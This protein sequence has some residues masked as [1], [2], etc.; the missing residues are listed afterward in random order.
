MGEMRGKRGRGRRLKSHLPSL[1]PST[2]RTSSCDL[3]WGVPHQGS[4]PAGIA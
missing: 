4:G 2:W 3:R 1:I